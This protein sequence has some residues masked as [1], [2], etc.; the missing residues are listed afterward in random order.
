MSAIGGDAVT[1]NLANHLNQARLSL[2]RRDTAAASHSLNEADGL[3]SDA[4]GP[5]YGPQF[6]YLKSQLQDLTAATRLIDGFQ[7]LRNTA[8]SGDRSSL[9]GKID[10]LV[11]LS[12][13][14]R[15]P[16]YFADVAQ[17]A[18]ESLG[19]VT[20]MRLT[21]STT[22]RN[23]AMDEQLTSSTLAGDVYANDLVRLWGPAT[24][25]ARVSTLRFDGPQFKQLG[26]ALITSGR[27]FLPSDK[28]GVNKSSFSNLVGFVSAQAGAPLRTIAP[29][30]LAQTTLTMA[31]SRR[32]ARWRV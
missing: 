14:A 1:S 17:S 22:S 5:V 30:R 25:M 7:E 27:E 8:R 23:T 11:R 28:G 12:S 13:D 6:A 31:M 19:A 24:T 16:F 9:K 21:Q 29:G 26:E 4:S 10:D 2:M 18:L 3:L 15:I 32:S 20:L